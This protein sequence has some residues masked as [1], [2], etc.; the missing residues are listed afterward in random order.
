VCRIIA[1]RASS[2]SGL[3]SLAPAGTFG[4]AVLLASSIAQAH[5]LDETLVGS[6]ILLSPARI[7]VQVDITPGA[8]L[9][10]DV[11]ALIDLDRDGTISPAEETALGQ[12]WSKQARVEMDGAAA[13]LRAV[14]SEVPDLETLLSG[15]GIIRI[16]GVVDVTQDAG[17][18]A[19]SFENGSNMPNSVFT[20]NA[21]KPADDQIRIVRQDRDIRQQAYS[22]QYEVAGPAAS[23]WT[24]SFGLSWLWGLMILP[25]LWPLFRLARR[26]SAS[27]EMAASG[28]TGFGRTEGIVHSSNVG[29]DS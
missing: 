17:N 1:E 10:R 16:L 4:A 19:F 21:L 13:S 22:V 12:Q 2:W 20:V 7:S 9:A 6:L 29:G 8:L 14:S 15:N 25:A 5:Q 28:M 24:R 27:M 18:H 3:R 26:S 23:A 11:H